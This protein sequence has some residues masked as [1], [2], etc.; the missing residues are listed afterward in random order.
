MFLVEQDYSYILIFEVPYILSGG[1]MVTHEAVIQ[2]LWLWKF[3]K[4]PSVSW[5]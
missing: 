1:Y 2:I 3:D 5:L 4:S